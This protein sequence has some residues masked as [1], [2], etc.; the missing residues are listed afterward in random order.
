MNIT[1]PKLYELRDDL[2]SK[3]GTIPPAVFDN[4]EKSFDIEYAHNSTAIEG[5]TLSLIET[6][7]VLEDKLNIDGKSLREIYEIVNH[8]NAFSYVKECIAESKPLIEN[9]V[10]ALSIIV[11]IFNI[12]FAQ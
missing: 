2:I 6:K 11:K 1:Y 3:K 9:I 7:A 8:D 10:K 4:F 12:I 5:N